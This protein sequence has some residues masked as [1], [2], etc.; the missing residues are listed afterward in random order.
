MFKNLRILLLL[1]VL[2]L[3]AGDFW[4]S[5]ERIASWEQS[6]WVRIY[7][8]NADGKESTQHFIQNL[9]EES[10]ASIEE[11][12]I[13]EAV[14]YQIDLD[15]PV[16]IK[17]GQELDTM[18]PL[19]PKKG[20]SLAIMWWSLQFRWWSYQVES[21]EEDVPV[22]VN[23]FV[24]YYDREHSESLGHSL[25]LEKGRIGIV[26][27]YASRRERYRNHFVIAH[28][29]LHTIGASDKYYMNDNQPIYP[30]GYA[31]PQQDP[32]YPQSIAEIMGGRIPLSESHAVM[33]NSLQDV[34]LGYYTAMEI[35][36][37]EIEEN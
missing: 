29:L 11:F 3:V 1:F 37:L 13:R 31:H 20:G 5:K 21:K 7:P 30:I 15:Q 22:H 2:L 16:Q 33:P 32:L 18:P 26:N 28:E 19:P 9:N 36:W 14:R 10:F 24:N 12:F 8:V 35:G 34:L 4:I 27:A 6:V 17:L 23:L 25:G